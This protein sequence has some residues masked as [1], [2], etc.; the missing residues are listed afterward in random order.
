M[1]SMCREN[2]SRL[3]QSKD[4]PD[5]LNVGTFYSN[6]YYLALKAAGLT[7]K[8]VELRAKGV[9]Y[10]GSLPETHFSNF[11]SPFSH[12]G[13]EIDYW[14]IGDGIDASHAMDALEK[15]LNLISCGT[16]IT[17]A[18]YVALR[19]LLGDE[20]F[21]ALFSS[22]SVA[23]L[24][25]SWNAGSTP[26]RYLSE[27]HPIEAVQEGDSVYFTGIET[28]YVIKHL[29]GDA[30]TYNTLA[31]SGG[32]KF[33]ALG[34]PP[35]GLTKDEVDET[36]MTDFNKPP[37]SFDPFL[38]DI[39]HKILGSMSPEKRHQTESFKDRT[40]TMEQY[41][42]LGGGQ[43]F[44]QPFRISPKKLAALINATLP[45]ACGLMSKWKTEAD[46]NLRVVLP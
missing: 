7:D 38:E 26:I 2:K 32:K 13:I 37:I 19:V 28:I 30:K 15:G 17:K 24:M 41:K 45:E 31:L 1:Q 25:M 27:S 34:F 9:F 12:S 33:I 18:Y 40:I 6:E 35:E 23:P 29:N 44:T 11:K 36:Q 39:R 5:R 21:S 10:H 16:A 42:T 43:M 3:A 20:K 22:N 4:D 8:I 14:K 46:L